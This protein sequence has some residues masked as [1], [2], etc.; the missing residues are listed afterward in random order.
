MQSDIQISDVRLRLDP[1]QGKMPFEPLIESLSIE[2]TSNAF[3]KIAEQ[4]VLQF[5]D[6]L[7]VE[8]TLSSVRLIA[9]G[10]EIVA[11]VKR[12][13][14]KA[15][16][17][18]VLGFSV[19]KEET[20]RV[21]V[22]ELD[23]PAWVPAQF[24]LDHGMTFASARPGFSRVPG[25][26]RAIDL[27]PAVVLAGAG[28]PVKLGEP[29]AWTIDSNADLLR[30]GY[31]SSSFATRASLPRPERPSDRPRGEPGHRIQNRLRCA[32]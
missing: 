17:R 9:G 22:S 15:E 7:P 13:I 12:S 27:K 16:L 11:R 4:A 19:Q 29:G 32:H 1:G 26:D 10:A 28:A 6:R 25:D 2:I 18:A 24:V 23:A 20:V 31:S 3:K 8:I 14:L 21:R 30:V 5:A